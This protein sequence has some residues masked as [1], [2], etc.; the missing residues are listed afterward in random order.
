MSL[1]TAL[2][3]KLDSLNAK[4][5]ALAAYVLAQP[6]E[7]AQ[8]NI[9][10]LARESG[11]STS[12]VSRFCKSLHFR[13]YSAFQRQLAV[14]LA[15]HAGATQYQDIVAGN[16]LSAIVSAITANHQRS[17]A[18]TTRL[19]DLVQLRQAID[20]LHQAEKIDLYGSATSSMVAGDFW[21]K[22]VRIGKA[23]AAYSDPHMQLTSASLLTP[24]DAAIGISYSGETPET[25]HALGCAA[26]RGATTI[27]I[28]RFG[29][30][31]LS[32]Q[33]DIRL[34]TSTSEV[35]I[36]RGDMASRMAALHVIDILFMGLV[37]EYFDVYVPRL[38]QSFQA[39]RKHTSQEERTST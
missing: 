9:T 29:T 15:E 16:P 4:E 14:E 18:D 38:E 34:F 26:E 10:D 12:T 1:L 20:A 27:S 11:S 8:L 35:G 23:A 6:Q 37:S 36:R 7:A 28:T 3:E 39:V 19:L 31:T 24:R 22:L 25:I 2:R 30:N 17:L 5:R 21:S 33:A 13:N 32:R